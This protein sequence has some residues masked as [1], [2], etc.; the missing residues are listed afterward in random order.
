MIAKAIPTNAVAVPKT[1][2][3]RVRVLLCIP[4]IREPA[5]AASDAMST[6]KVALLATS[7]P[8]MVELNST[9]SVM[10]PLAVDVDHDRRKAAMR[11]V[12]QLAVHLLL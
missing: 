9:K 6:R 4:P 7:D 2:A 5:I 12:S 3:D 10:Y 11:N 1:I 8:T